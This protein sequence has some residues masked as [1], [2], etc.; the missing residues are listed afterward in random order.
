LTTR[1]ITEWRL[2]VMN[3]LRA[4]F[5]HPAEIDGRPRDDVVS[6]RDNDLVCVWWPGWQVIERD[7]TL[8]QPRL[9]I[10]AWPGRSRLK[11]PA[12]TDEGTSLE[13]LGMKLLLAFPRSTQAGGFFVPNL[14]CR[15]IRAVP[16]YSDNVYRVE[17]ELL[18][19]TILE[20]A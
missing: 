12:Q 11:A 1:T 19:Y 5:P 8:A 7:T 15:L 4:T 16:D 9:Q 20:G 2:A 13:E 17:A 18:A 14:A 3:H 10:R 6:R